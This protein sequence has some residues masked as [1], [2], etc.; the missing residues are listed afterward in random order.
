MLEQVFILFAD[1]LDL[2]KQFTYFYHRQFR[3]R[4][5]KDFMQP[6]LRQK[7]DKLHREKVHKCLLEGMSVEM[8]RKLQLI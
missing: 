3:N 8:I 4:R 7:L 1:H 5:K 6:Q 2:L